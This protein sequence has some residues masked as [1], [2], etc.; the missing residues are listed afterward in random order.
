MTLCRGESLLRFITSVLCKQPCSMKLLSCW[1]E[2]R[3]STLTI[4]NG[5][6]KLACLQGFIRGDAMHVYK[7]SNI[8]HFHWKLLFSELLDSCIKCEINA[9]PVSGA[10]SESHLLHCTTVAP[11]YSARPKGKCLSHSNICMSANWWRGFIL[12]ELMSG[13]EFLCH[14]TSPVSRVVWNLTCW[15][16]D[17]KKNK[18]LHLAQTLCVWNAYRVEQNSQKLPI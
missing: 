14:T 15:Q 13:Q 1:D 5:R 9:M 11:F 8:S 4:S 16:E 2:K 3:I 17:E 12:W 18:C 6:W 10:H 7:R